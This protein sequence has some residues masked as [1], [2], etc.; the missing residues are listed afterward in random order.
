MSRRL[1]DA[2]RGSGPEI[3]GAFV[4]RRLELCWIAGSLVI[5]ARL[6]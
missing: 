1:E 5:Q 4:F 2:G 6:L 3:V